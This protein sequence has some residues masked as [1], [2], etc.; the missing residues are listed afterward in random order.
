MTAPSALRAH[1]LARV[2]A[3]HVRLLMVAPDG[4]GVAWAER[5][6]KQIESGERLRSDMQQWMADLEDHT[7]RVERRAYRMTVMRW[8]HP[9]VLGRAFQ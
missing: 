1:Y 9:A 6:I 7:R 3:V 8:F 5:T 4:C 2:K